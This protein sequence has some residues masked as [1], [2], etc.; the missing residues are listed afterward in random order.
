MRAAGFDYF[1]N[2][3]RATYAQRDY[4]VANP[5]GWEGYSKYGKS[6]KTYDQLEPELKTHYE[7]NASGRS[8]LEWEKA[9]DAV[10]MAELKA[11]E[12]ELEALQALERAFS[13]ETQLKQAQKSANSTAFATPA[14]STQSTP[15]IKMTP[16]PAAAAEPEGR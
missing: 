16:P 8:K 12:K 11:K 3:R 10:R 6:G 1:E 7:R 9:K 13:A 4:A 5:L 14:A 15:Q 2:S